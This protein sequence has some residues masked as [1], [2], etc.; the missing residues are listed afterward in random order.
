LCGIPRCAGSAATFS[1]FIP[2]LKAR[3][4]YGVMIFIL[5]FTM[6]AVSSYRVD[7]LLEFAHERLTTVA[8]GVTICLFT[9]LFVFPIWAGEDLHNLAADSLEKLA[10]FLEGA[11]WN[12]SSSP[13]Q[14]RSN[15]NQTKPN[16]L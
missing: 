3:Y 15:L 9:T 8:V 6:V 16:R 11:T 4:D 10:E 2:E 1:R 7:E 12:E 13:F 5:T 14:S